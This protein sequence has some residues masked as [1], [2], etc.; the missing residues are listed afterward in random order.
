LRILITQDTDWIK[1]YPGQQHHLAERLILRGHEIRVI[2]YEILWKTE[3]K[4]ELISSGRVFNNVS[5][6]IGS[7]GVTVIRPGIIKIPY[8]DYISALFS[9]GYEINRQINEFC[10]NIIIGHS[11]LTNYISMILAKKY[12]I[13]FAFHMTDAQHTIIPSKIL[14]PIGKILE[15]NILKNA[16]KVIVINDMLKDYAIKMGSTFDKTEV[17]KAGIDLDRYDPKINGNKIREKFGIKE[18]DYVLFFMGWLYNFSGLKEVVIEL[19]KI[20]EERP[21]IKLL[22]VG[23]GDA[24]EGLKKIIDDFDLH[25]QVIL[26][27]RQPY[28]KIPEFIA[29]SNICLLPSYNNETMKNIVPIKLYEYMALGKPV[30]AT[31]LSGVVKEFGEDHGVVYVSKPEC[32][33]NKAIYLIDNN[34]LDEYGFKARKF[35]ENYNWDNVVV[36]FENILKSMFLVPS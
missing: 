30:I 7:P 6:V 23:H 4:K 33:L 31:N 36:S 27:G 1:R 2:D 16:D 12:D 34:M 29:S 24:F 22:V 13:P 9:Y 19:A 8:L 14:Q 35:A 21:N 17:V 15:M 25:C 3:G 20:K 18:T 10:P 26:A 5:K 11:I 28:D 32:V